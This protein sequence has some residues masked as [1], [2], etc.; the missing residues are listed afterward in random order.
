M[1]PVNG[2]VTG[3]HAPADPAEWGMWH[4][5]PRAKAPFASA[6]PAA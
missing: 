6:L 3:T 1:L 4:H 2:T 5:V